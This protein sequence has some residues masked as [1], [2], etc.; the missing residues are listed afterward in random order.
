[1]QLPRALSLSPILVSVTPSGKPCLIT[2]ISSSVVDSG[3]RSP[4]LLPAVIRPTSLVPAIVVEIVGMA[5]SNV[6]AE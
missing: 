2:S 5:P 6:S 3:T 1:M 4:F